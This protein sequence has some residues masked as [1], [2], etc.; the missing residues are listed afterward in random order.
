MRGSRYGSARAARLSQGGQYD[1]DDAIEGAQ[2]QQKAQITVRDE[3]RTCGSFQTGRLQ[4][5]CGGV[6]RHLRRVRLVGPNDAVLH[7]VQRKHAAVDD[8]RRAGAARKKS[9]ASVRGILGPQKMR[10]SM[11]VFVRKN[12]GVVPL[13]G[14]IRT[15]RATPWR[16][17]G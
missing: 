10:H 11:D 1:A 14:P 17:T 3:E 8:V 4:G 2:G 16:C 9:R 15:W 13:G 12:W 6:G 5:T 7:V